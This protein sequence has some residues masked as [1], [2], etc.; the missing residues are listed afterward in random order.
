VRSSTVL[1]DAWRAARASL[2]ICSDHAREQ[3][4]WRA[5]ISSRLP[6]VNV[7]VWTGFDGVNGIGRPSSRSTERGMSKLCK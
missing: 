1:P 3:Y 6:T 2:K 4:Q 5:S 7:A